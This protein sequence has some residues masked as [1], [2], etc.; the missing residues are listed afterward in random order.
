MAAIYKRVI[1]KYKSMQETMAQNSLIFNELL[2]VI[3]RAL[4][5]IG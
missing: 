5:K 1:W 3:N 4:V 2:G